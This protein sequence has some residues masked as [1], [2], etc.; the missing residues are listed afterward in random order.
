MSAD[1][2]Q[3]LDELGLAEGAMVP[4]GMGAVRLRVCEVRAL[5]LRIGSDPEPKNSVH[6]QAWG[7][8]KT[9]RNKLQAIVEDW[10]VA[11]PGVSIR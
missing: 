6:G 2:G 7:V 10:V 3:S 8:T 1:L 5:A 9:K 4:P 11:I